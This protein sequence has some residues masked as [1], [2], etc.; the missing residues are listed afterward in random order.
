VDHG[1]GGVLRPV[2]ESVNDHTAGDGAVGTDAASLRGSGDLELPHLR[3]G[4]REVK[5]ECDGSA[6][7]RC[8]EETAASEFHGST[9]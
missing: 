5:T 6:N 1:C 4:A 9:S 3:A 2:A 7:S 8:L